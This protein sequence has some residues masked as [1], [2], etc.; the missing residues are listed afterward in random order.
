ME[1]S[2]FNGI[3]LIAFPKYWHAT[4][5]HEEK[6]KQCLESDLERA[7]RATGG[8]LASRLGSDAAPPEAGRRRGSHA[9]EALSMTAPL[10]MLQCFMDSLCR[11][12]L[13]LFCSLE[14]YRPRYVHERKYH[15]SSTVI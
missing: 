13:Q 7:G 3:S 9:A 5:L 2:K 10:A 15:R 11:A 12:L 14:S 1:A 8:C 6:G 4:N